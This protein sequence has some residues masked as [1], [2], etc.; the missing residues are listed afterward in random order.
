MLL[1]AEMFSF[2]NEVLPRIQLVEGPADDGETA[3][4][5]NECFDHFKSPK[6]DAIDF[7]GFEVMLK[8]LFVEGETGK[9]FH[10]PKSWSVEYFEK[11]D[12]MQ[13]NLIDRKEFTDMWLKWIQFI[14]KPRSALI[15]V[16]VQNDFISGSLAIHHCP[17]GHRGE[18]VVP[19]INRLIESIPFEL[20]VYSFDWHPSD[21]ISFYENYN[22]RKII[23]SDGTALNH[24]E[25]GEIKPLEVVTFEGPPLTEQKLW[26]KHCVQDTWGSQLHPDLLVREYQSLN[27]YKGTNSVIDSYSAFWDNGKLSETSLNTDLTSRGI[28]DV[29]VCGIAYDYC[30]GS[31]A[32][33]GNEYGFKTTLIEDASRGVD[34]KTITEMKKKLINDNAAVVH[35]DRILAMVRGE[36]RRPEHGYH[37]C[38][39]MRESSDSLPASNNR[40]A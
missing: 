29:F 17:A 39:F 9:P 28:T 12:T 20:V 15:I 35:S 32:L 3:A 10:A 27:V 37:L 14:L 13:D 23:H 7:V 26:N 18:E 34:G 36:E 16:D 30:V 38:H 22:K 2:F 4:V 31:T 1:N 8:Q 5:I 40:E 11:F 25:L 6:H 33:H 19:V 24:D 21:H